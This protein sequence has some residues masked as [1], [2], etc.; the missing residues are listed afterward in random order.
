MLSQ[1]EA[2][3]RRTG[4]SGSRLRKIMRA[5]ATRGRCSEIGYFEEGR[6]RSASESCLAES[7]S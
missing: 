2:G 3:S 4:T 5:N 7:N 6:L 1:S